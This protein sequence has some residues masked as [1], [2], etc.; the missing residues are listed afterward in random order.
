MLAPR[1]LAWPRGEGRRVASPKTGAVASRPKG[2][3]NDDAENSVRTDFGGTPM[4]SSM[5]CRVRPFVRD[6][7]TGQRVKSGRV[8]EWR[9]HAY[10]SIHCICVA[11]WFVPVTNLCTSARF[12]LRLITARASV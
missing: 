3:K 12:F 1:E 10:P 4:L 9:W 6:G 2:L 8:A 7:T 11:A 5:A